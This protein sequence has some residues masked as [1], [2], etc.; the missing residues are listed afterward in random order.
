V[1][2]LLYRLL[3]FS[4]FVIQYVN[5]FTLAGLYKFDRVFVPVM[6]GD[7]VL[8]QLEPLQPQVL[9]QVVQPVQMCGLCPLLIRDLSQLGCSHM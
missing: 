1:V 3:M 5:P 8:G 7:V 6:L 2:L 9:L 4:K